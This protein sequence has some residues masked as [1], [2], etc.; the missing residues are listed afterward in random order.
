MT[1]LLK[2][3]GLLK[4]KS[5]SSHKS[6]ETTV[7]TGSSS[8]QGLEG[9]LISLAKEILVS[10]ITKHFP[11]TI[12]VRKVIPIDPLSVPSVTPI[13][14][15]PVTLNQAS[16]TPVTPGTSLN[17][18]S[19]QLSQPQQMQQP[20]AVTTVTTVVEESPQ[21]V[22]FKQGLIQRARALKLP[23]TPLDDLIYQLGGEEAVCPIQH[24]SYTIHSV[25]IVAIITLLTLI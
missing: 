16:V 13:P 20:V 15:A 8:L 17:M 12:K 18:A 24:L 14:G 9:G 1:D 21:L 5:S 22:A 11:T 23:P 2:D 19:G 6:Q 4:K 25:S 3:T 10:F 7:D